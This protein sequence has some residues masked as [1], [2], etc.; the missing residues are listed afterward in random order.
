VCDTP[1]HR[2]LHAR[3][4]VLHRDLRRRLGRLQRR[5]GRRLRGQSHQRRYDLRGL[6]QRLRRG[7]WTQLDL[8]PGNVRGQRLLSRRELQP[9]GL[10]RRQNERLRSRPVARSEQLRRLR[11]RLQPAQWLGRVHQ[12]GL[13]GRAVQSRLR[14]L[15]RESGERLRTKH[16]DGRR[17]LRRVRPELRVRQRRRGVRRWVLPAR[18]Q[19]W[20]RG[21]RRQSQYRVRGKPE[22][23]HGALRELQQHLRASARDRR[24]LLGGGLR[25]HRLL[26]RLRRLRPECGEWM[27]DIAT[28]ALGLWRMQ[29]RVCLAPKRDGNVPGRQLQHHLQRGVP[30]LQRLVLLDHRPHA[31]RLH[32]QQLPAADRRHRHGHL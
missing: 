16:L 7:Q 25:V 15:R 18:V 14:G 6:R 29:S 20:I 28:H 4:C 23:R 22:H 32:L 11:H 19:L 17:E 24:E 5:S 30:R 1:C 8:R 12:L 13:R 9:A 21:L 10:R 3:R 2:R 26:G 31:L 27:R